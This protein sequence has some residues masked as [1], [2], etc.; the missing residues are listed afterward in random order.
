MIY[1]FSSGWDNVVEIW[2]FG[3]I[4]EAFPDKVTSDI[5]FIDEAVVPCYNPVVKIIL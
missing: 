5:D 3:G 1:I 4:T 2:K